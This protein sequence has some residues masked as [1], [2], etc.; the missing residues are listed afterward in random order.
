MLFRSAKTMDETIAVL[1]VDAEHGEY[2]IRPAGRAEY[3][4]TAVIFKVY[5]AT[6][7]SLKRLI[8]DENGDYVYQCVGESVLQ[9]EVYPASGMAVPMVVS[10]RNHTLALKSDGTVW[11]WGSNNF[12]Q[13]GIAAGWSNSNR[14]WKVSCVTYYGK[15][16][17]T[18]W[19][20]QGYSVKIGRAHV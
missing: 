20:D 5:E 15:Y 18:A 2:V 10:G 3:G 11:A 8:V 7:D 13:L 19:D 17:T 16:Y 14:D 9:V 1:E 6:R 4:T 12:G